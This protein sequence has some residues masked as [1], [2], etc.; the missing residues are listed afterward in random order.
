MATAEFPALPHDGQVGLG[1]DGTEWKEREARA[2]AGPGA[3][4]WPPHLAC[5]P[6]GKSGNWP[7]WSLVP[8]SVL[9]PYALSLHQPRTH[10]P[11]Q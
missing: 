9:Q 3:L 11:P 6:Q 4:R 5:P 7:H 10:H 1:S 8:T 2:G